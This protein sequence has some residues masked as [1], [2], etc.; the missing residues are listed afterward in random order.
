[1]LGA[2]C[3]ARLGGPVADRLGRKKLLLAY[4]IILPPGAATSALANGFSLF[5]IGQLLVGVG[6][7]FDFP[8]SSS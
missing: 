2:A 4:M 7:G 8:A 1:V 6:V 3:G 5:F